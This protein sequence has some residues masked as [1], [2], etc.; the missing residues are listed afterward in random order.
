MS[1][2][3]PKCGHDLPFEAACEWCELRTQLQQAER[4]NAAM[5]KALENAPGKHPDGVDEAIY[6]YWYDGYRKLALSPVAGQV[7]S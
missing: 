4:Q 3:C 1:A 2:E 5:R 6:R 7:P